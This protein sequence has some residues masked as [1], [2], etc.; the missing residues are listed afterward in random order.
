MIVRRNDVR[1]RSHLTVAHACNGGST[2]ASLHQTRTTLV[3]SGTALI[4]PSPG[5][6]NVT[7]NL[8]DC[9]LSCVL[10]RVKT[11]CGQCLSRCSQG[12]WHVTQCFADNIVRCRA[13]QLFALSLRAVMKHAP[14]L[15]GPPL[16]LPRTRLA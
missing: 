9:T 11:L 10:Q 12:L 7:R 3:Q 14:T 2:T 1:A 5:N 13:S 4:K 8:A 15:A 6:A 16:A